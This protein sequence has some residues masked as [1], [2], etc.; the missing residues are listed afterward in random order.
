MFR[1]LLLALAAVSLLAQ[2]PTPA[3]EVASVKPSAP[4]QRGAGIVPE[5][6]GLKV[7]NVPLAYLIREAYGVQTFQVS[8]IPAWA[9]SARY[10]IDARAA[11]R[12]ANK[13]LLREMLAT[14]LA[15]RFHLAIHRG[16]K[17]LPIYLLVVAK[18]GPKMEL[19]EN[20]PAQHGI[21]YRNGGTTILGRAADMEEVAESLSFRIGRQVTDHTDLKGRYNFKIEFT[22]DE[23]V[24]RFGQETGPAGDPDGSSLFTALQEQAGLRLHPGRG[25][26]E[27]IIVDRVD[28]PTED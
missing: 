7:R 20:P 25:P 24:P 22:P 1:T 12:Q 16:S 21:D 11:D 2:T 23:A 3:F 18:G 13:H 8:G 9:N 5:P 26:V 6:G 10:D 15:D 28:R 4:N 19:V 27:F 17:E 14:L